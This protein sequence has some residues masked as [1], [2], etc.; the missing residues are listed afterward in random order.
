MDDGPGCEKS[1]KGPA[2]TQYA[3]YVTKFEGLTFATVH[4]AGHLVPATR[5]AE[6]LQVLRNFLAGTW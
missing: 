6:G 3:G 5:P 1:P 4:G 2:C